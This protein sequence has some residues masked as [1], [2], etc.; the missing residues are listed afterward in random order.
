MSKLSSLPEFN[1]LVISGSRIEHFQG[2]LSLIRAKPESIAFGVAM[3][4]WRAFNEPLRVPSE[5]SLVSSVRRS[6]SKLT[7]LIY[8]NSWQYRDKRRV[9]IPPKFLTL[10]F[11]QNITS[12]SDANKYLTRFIR[13]VNLNFASLLVEPLKYVCVPEFQERGAVHFHL[14]I[15]NLPFADRIFSRLR[16]FWPD[17]FEL[18]TIARTSGVGYVSDYVIKYISKQT[19]D[20]RFFNKKR[21]SVSRFLL[22]PLVSHEPIFN[23]LATR[24]VSGFNSRCYTLAL[25]IGVLFCNVYLLPEG[26]R[27]K[28]KYLPDAPFK[29]NRGSE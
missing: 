14:V 20:S 21:Y 22:V 5:L 15:F 3:R 8:A 27:L 13:S 26:W 18:K 1:K 25:P 6:R 4:R 10:T 2:N 7:R 11:Q 12:L 9:P 17:R 23:H 19:Y 24:S 28:Y 16:Q 29:S